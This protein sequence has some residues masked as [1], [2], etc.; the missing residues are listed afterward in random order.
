MCTRTK[1]SLTALILSS[2]LSSANAM[3]F[4]VWDQ[5]PGA[6]GG[7][8]TNSAF[9]N[10]M[11]DQNFS[12]L[13]RFDTDIRLSGMDIYM[14][15]RQ[16]S[17]GDAATIRIRT[18]SHVGSLFEFD[19]IVSLI[20]T[21]GTTITIPALRRVHVDFSIPV[22]L[23]AGEDYWIGMS[24]TDDQLF[25]AGIKGGSGPLL[26]NRLAWYDETDFVTF[27]SDVG[28]QAFRLWGEVPVNVPEHSTITLLGHSPKAIARLRKQRPL[29]SDTYPR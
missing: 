29:S 24:G 7:T 18:G 27:A 11:E 25:Q 6:I 23:L 3:P 9:T 12:D 13:V 17:V 20:D 21:D 2:W 8:M 1:W 4:V 15:F 28:D 26:D 19:E 5:S 22:N 16:G 14:D 10:N